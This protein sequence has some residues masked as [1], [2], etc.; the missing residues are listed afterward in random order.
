MRLLHMRVVCVEGAS[1]PQNCARAA[2]FL[3][4]HVPGFRFRDVL[5]RRRRYVRASSVATRD[6]EAKTAEQSW[7]ASPRL[8]RSL[9]VR[10]FLLMGVYYSVLLPCSRFLRVF[11]F[12]LHS[13]AGLTAKF[14]FTSPVRSTKWLGCAASQHSV[15]GADILRKYLGSVIWSHTGRACVTFKRTTF[16]Q[17][18]NEFI[19]YGAIIT[20]LEET[21]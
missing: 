19:M 4:C 9:L 2:P 21:A 6:Q 13:V 20:Y 16:N 12:L 15:P 10:F 7:R 17:W 11:T 1:L 18:E 5:H 14:E 8:L 3:K